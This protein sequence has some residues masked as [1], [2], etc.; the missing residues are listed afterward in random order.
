MNQLNYVTVF[1]GSSSGKNPDYTHE[2]VKIGKLLAEQ[3]IGLVYG[4]AKI[5]LMGT[6]ADSVLAAGGQVIGVLPSF[7]A[8]KEIAHSSLSKIFYV[9]TM[10]ER[11]A[12][13]NELSDGVIALPGGFGTMDELFEMLTWAQLGLH[14][15]PIGLLNLNGFYDH[16]LN[17]IQSMVET[18]FLKPVN[19]NMLLTH[20]QS[21]KLLEL[22]KNYQA[23]LVPKWI[24]DE[25]I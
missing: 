10:H 6:V 9:Q 2:A 25:E 8:S 20:H 1:C 16:L 18:G 5:G 11:K 22:M 7:L 14:Q 13:M 12:K 21:S 15:K 23:P 4:G 24:T 19:Q 3:N 17:F